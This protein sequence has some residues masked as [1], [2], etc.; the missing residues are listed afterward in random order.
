MALNPAFTLALSELVTRM[1]Q[2]PREALGPDDHDA[3][4]VICQEVARVLVLEDELKG[5]RRLV[6]QNLE[7]FAAKLTEDERVRETQMTDPARGLMQWFRE[8]G[9]R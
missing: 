3:L 1:L 5:R 8:M 9:V 6:I 2:A 4:R 7:R